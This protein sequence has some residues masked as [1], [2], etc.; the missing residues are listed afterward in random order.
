[1]GTMVFRPR[2]LEPVLSESGSKPS[3]EFLILG[4]VKDDDCHDYLHEL[5]SD[6]PEAS[7]LEAL[8]DLTAQ[9]S[10]DAIRLHGD[11]GSLHVC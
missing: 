7:L 5:G 10:L 4:N 8:D 9:S 2:P 1:M 11:E 6:Q 3:P